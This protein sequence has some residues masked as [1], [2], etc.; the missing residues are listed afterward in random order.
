MYVRDEE[1]QHERKPD[2][3]IRTFPKI[4]RIPPTKDNNTFIGDRPGTWD[5]TVEAVPALA[6]PS[7]M[8]D[9]NTSGTGPEEDVGKEVQVSENRKAEHRQE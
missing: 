5:E 1:A 4:H 6:E 7:R 3:V 8:P 2:E 9:Q